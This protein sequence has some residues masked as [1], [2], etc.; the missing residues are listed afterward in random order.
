MAWFTTIDNT[1]RHRLSGNT[2]V[3]NIWWRD[4]SD[5]IQQKT[6]NRTVR[7]YKWVGVDIEYADRI[8]T[9]LSREDNVTDAHWELAEAGS[10]TIFQTVE[11]YT[12]WADV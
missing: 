6:R 7:R 3:E 1:N 10:C 8:I 12:T 9:E 5:G 4:S 11:T 2:F